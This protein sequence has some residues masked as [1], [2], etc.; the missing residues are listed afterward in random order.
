MPNGTRGIDWKINRIEEPDVGGVG[1]IKTTIW[2]GGYSKTGE[3]AQGTGMN[4]TARNCKTSRLNDKRSWW[5]SNWIMLSSW[6]NSSMKKKRRQLNPGRGWRVERRRNDIYG[7]N[8]YRS[9]CLI[10]GSMSQLV[11]PSDLRPL[12]LIR[13]STLLLELFPLSATSVA[14]PLDAT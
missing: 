4:R 12:S 5:W 11:W 10:V 14:V 2:V 1:D 8:Q 6:S 13:K 7:F 9:L 3:R